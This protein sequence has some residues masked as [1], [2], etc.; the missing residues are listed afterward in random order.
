MRTIHRVP[1]ALLT[2]C[3]LWAAPGA[4]RAA[5]AVGSRGDNKNLDEAKKLLAK[6]SF[7]PALE[8]LKLAEGLPGN[9]PRHLAEICALRASALLALPPTAE[10]AKQADEALVQLFHA[11][12]AGAALQV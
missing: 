1:W 6:G 5:S 3:A 7:E 10:R 9:S 11:D 4:A 12:A 8:E 2:A